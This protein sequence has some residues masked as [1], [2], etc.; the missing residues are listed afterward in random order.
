MLDAQSS[1]YSIDELQ[2]VG[3]QRL[4]VPVPLGNCNKIPSSMGNST[5]CFEG[6][7]WRLGGLLESG[8]PIVIPG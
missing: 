8:D 6:D 7:L 1:E 4:L 5:F 3:S 2:P